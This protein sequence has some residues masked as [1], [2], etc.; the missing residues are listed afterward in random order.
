MAGLTYC[1]G[2]NASGELGIG[3]T[4]G[5]NDTPVLLPMQHG[6]TLLLPGLGEHTCGLNGLGEIYCWGLNTSGQV[7]VAAGAP[8]PTPVM[9]P[10]W[11]R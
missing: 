6:I 2:L 8:E 5:T 10:G 11:P 7:G 9:V 1:W 3:V 4:G